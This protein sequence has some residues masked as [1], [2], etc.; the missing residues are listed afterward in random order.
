MYDIVIVGA[1]PSGS[2]LARLLD[3]K[4]KILI[5][6]RRYLGQAPSKGFE[7]SC[8]GLLAPD[9]Q[10]MLAILGLGIP[11]EILVGPQIFTVRTID[12]KNS[13]EQFYQRHYINFDREKFDRWLVS[14]IPGNVEKKFGVRFR[15]FTEKNNHVEFSYFENGKR[16]SGETRT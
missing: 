8:G 6:D 3:K 10:E 11:K 13:I 7:K 4:F 2:T 14:L 16:I 15:N 1:G 5:L 12:L 9:A